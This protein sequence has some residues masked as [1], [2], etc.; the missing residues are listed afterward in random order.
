MKSAHGP[1]DGRGRGRRIARARHRPARPAARWQGP[2]A[3]SKRLPIERPAAPSW[4]ARR[5]RAAPDR[6]QGHRCA[7]S[8]RARPARVDS[9]RPPD[10]QDRHCDRH[11]S[12]PARQEC[13]VRLLR[14]RPARVRRRQG[15]GEPAGKGAMDYTVVVVA[16]GNDAPGLAYIRLTPPPASR[17]ISWKRAAMC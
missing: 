15:R 16:E 17:S 2:V 14:H 12:E 9:G 10:G 3:S 5:S 13:A 1:R 8:H 11:H 6:P 4:T 7:H